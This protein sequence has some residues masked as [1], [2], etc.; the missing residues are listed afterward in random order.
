MAQP[1]P[2]VAAPKAYSCYTLY[3]A[4]VSITL[5][6]QPLRLCPVYIFCGELPGLVLTL[7]VVAI[8]TAALT[9]TLILIYFH[10]MTP[11]GRVLALILTLTLAPSVALTLTGAARPA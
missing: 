11:I 7:A 6:L 8:L 9:L 3:R 5:V 1:T 2:R 10:L 4:P